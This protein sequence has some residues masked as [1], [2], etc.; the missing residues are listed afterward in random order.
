MSKLSLSVL[1]CLASF[2]THGV[3]LEFSPATGP[4]GS[5]IETQWIESGF[6]ISSDRM[7]SQSA[8]VVPGW[9]ANGTDVLSFFKDLTGTNIVIR[10]TLDFSFDAISVDLAEYSFVYPVPT[11]VQFIGFLSAGGIVTTSF[12]TDGLLDGPGGQAD[13][14]TFEFPSTFRSLSRIEV[15]SHLFAMDNL[16]LIPV[17]EP[18]VALL[19]IMSSLLAILGFR[20]R[21]FE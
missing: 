9:P 18:S 1:L 13:F 7:G 10:S 15:P 21:V 3:T 6:V 17:P 16:Q 4:G 20:Y 19:L 12:T 11:T 5:R 2:C 8:G 14:E